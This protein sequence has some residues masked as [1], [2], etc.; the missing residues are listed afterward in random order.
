MYAKFSDCES[1]PTEKTTIITECSK[2]YPN[3]GLYLR[4]VSFTFYVTEIHGK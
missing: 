4:Y 3:E 2:K 1:Q